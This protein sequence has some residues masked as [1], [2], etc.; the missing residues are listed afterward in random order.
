MDKHQIEGLISAGLQPSR[1]TVSGDDGAHFE[2]LVISE[3]FAG[4]GTLQR[5]RLVYAALGDAMG[6]EIHALS[7]RTLTPAE[8]AASAAPGSDSGPA[9][10][11]DPK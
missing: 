7:L 10:D 11:S 1:V 4:K 6:R 2:A 8:A 5:H 9:P 3:S